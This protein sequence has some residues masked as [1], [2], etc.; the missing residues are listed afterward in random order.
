MQPNQGGG[1]N[2]YQPY[3]AE[4]MQS[5]QQTGIPPQMTPEMMQ[6]M[7]TGQQQWQ[8]VPYT[9]P[10]QQMT[11]QQIQQMQYDAY[12]WQMQQMQNGQPMPG[13]PFMPG[14]QPIQQTIYNQPGGKHPKKPKKPRAPG[15]RRPLRSVLITILVLGVLGGGIAYYLQNIASS[16]P[17]TAVIELG[18]M[19]TSYTGDALIVRNETVFDDEGVQNIKYVAQEGSVAYRGNVLCY[20][21]S[22]GYSTAEMTTLQDYRDQIND[23]QQSL[24]ASETAYDQRMERL[25][26]DVVERGLEV[27]SLVH[28]SRGNLINQEQILSTAITQR[29]NYFRS[30]Y[31]TDM[32]LNRLYDDE[33]TQEQRIESWIKPSV[34]TQESIVSFYTDGFETALSPSAYLNY[35]PTQ[36]RSMINGEKPQSSASDRGRTDLYRLVKQ[37]NYAV[38]MLIRNNTWSPKDGETYK[39]VLEQF[40][41]T[42]VNAQVL[43]SSRTGSE[44]LVRLAVLGDVKDVLYMRTCQAQLGE[45]ADCLVV[46]SAALYNQ[47]DQRGVIIT[48]DEGVQRFAPVTVLQ[49]EAGKAYISSLQTGVLKPGMSVQLFY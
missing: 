1:G 28:G 15:Q 18:S 23:Y 32:R 47:N 22:T 19:S 6:Q 40:S 36:V 5:W 21:Y 49:E 27:R 12:V 13:A 24:L 29:Q 37:D 25:E 14:G 34:A 10:L 7:W 35:T 46:P 41:S 48:D 45:N 16:H 38:L 20:V 9:V 43:S 31:S 44:L 26:T 3:T 11:P 42:I 8:N 30:K 39:L 2:P 17:A 4:Q 33:S